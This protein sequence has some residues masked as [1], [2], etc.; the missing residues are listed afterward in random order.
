EYKTI[1]RQ[2]VKTPATTR[3][4]SIP[5]EYRTVTK[6]VLKK[7]GG[8]NEWKEVLCESKQ[9]PEKIR[10]IQLALRAKG[11]D[12]GPIDNILGSLTRAAL[13]KYQTAMKLPVGKLDT[14]T[15]RSLGV[16]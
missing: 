9:T 13:E 10:Q 3:E 2:V 7:K 5:A 12:P 15:L 4:I 6:S 14:E 16:E 8:Y 1:T 11:Y